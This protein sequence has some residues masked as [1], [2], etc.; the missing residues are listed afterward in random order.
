MAE[1]I[2]TCPKCEASFPLDQLLRQDIEKTLRDK[3]ESEAR[4]KELA[5]SQRDLALSKKAQELQ[6]QRD[7]LEEHISEETS[8]REVLI[9]ATI[10]QELGGEFALKLKAISDELTAKKDQLKESQAKELSWRKRE[11]EL[12]EQ[13]ATIE[14]E[15]ARKVAEERASL[16]ATIRKRLEEEQRQKQVATESRERE[17]SQR[18]KSVDQKAR[19]LQTKLDG[20]EQRIAEEAK[21]KEA[22]IKEHIQENLKLE[23]G[24]KLKE[25]TADLVQKK[26]LLKESQEREL[27]WRKRERELEERAA[28]IELEVSRR[29]SEGVRPLEESI[30]IRVAEEHR[31]KDDEKDRKLKDMERQVEEMRNRLIQGS[32]QLQG[33][34]LETNIENVLAISFPY[35]V[36]EPVPTGI[37]G[38]DIVHTVNDQL[39]NRCGAIVWEVKNTKNW[40]DSWIPKLK[41]DLD[42]I[43]GDVGVIASNVLPKDAGPIDQRD[44]IWITEPKLAVTLA[45]ILRTT[46]IQ[47]ATARIA[48]QGMS[49]KSE[50]VYGYLTS[51]GFKRR[52]EAIVDAFTSMKRDLD[53]EKKV[54]RKQWDKREKQLELSV[55]GTVGLY[56]DLQGIIGRSLAAIPDLE[57]ESLL[58]AGT[59]EPDG[60]AD[61]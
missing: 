32:Q 54:I 44:G 31:L 51:S 5:L 2:I 20:I 43:K 8:K 15:V 10:Q 50:A 1:T 22:V 58:E 33:D 56:G 47:V 38:A 36:I 37:R 53:L 7:S 48:S 18:E 17:L 29:L 40:S 27:A 24:V 23:F 4:S 39:G 55:T 11:R 28:E 52:V 26:E 59:S 42:A 35:D 3:V 46:M 13:S 12:E 19:E 41:A 30:R 25:L 14:L 6:Q 60:T 34:I 45:S 16:E 21:K 57:L 9:R 61:T 49:Q